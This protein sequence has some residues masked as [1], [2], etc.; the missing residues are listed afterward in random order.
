M[1]LNYL[2]QGQ[3][4]VGLVAVLAGH[5]VWVPLQELGFKR[6]ND[7]RKAIQWR[8]LLIRTQHLHSNNENMIFFYTLLSISSEQPNIIHPLIA[9]QCN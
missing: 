5:L 1:Q 7:Q 6:R 8:Q 2:W 3:R 4:R 9:L